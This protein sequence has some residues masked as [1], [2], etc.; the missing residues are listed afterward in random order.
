VPPLRNVS[1]WLRQSLLYWALAV[2]SLKAEPRFKAIG[3]DRTIRTRL[4]E[5]GFR[6]MAGTV[7]PTTHDRVSDGGEMGCG[8]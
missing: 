5:W 6:F 2:N 1:L 4:E 7:N 3:F 8:R